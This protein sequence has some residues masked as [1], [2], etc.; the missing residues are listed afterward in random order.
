MI[1]SLLFVKYYFAVCQDIGMILES[2]KAIIA[3]RRETQ[4]L[5]QKRLAGIMGAKESM[6]SAILSGNRGLSELWIERFCAALNITL[7]ELEKP[8]PHIYDPIEIREYYDKLKK[9]HEISHVPGFRAASRAIDDWLE[10]AEAGWDVRPAAQ[11]IAIPKINEKPGISYSDSD[12]PQ[13]VQSVRVPYYDA[14]PACDPRE[15][16]PQG[17]IWMDIIHSKS[18]GS[19]YT[20]RVNGDS[21]SPDYLDGDVVLMDH[22]PQPC[23]GDIVAALIDGYESTLKIY[24]RIGDNIILTPIETKRHSPRT[25]HA[26]RV[27]IQ[28]VLVEIVRRIAKRRS[29]P[30]RKPS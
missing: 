28:G 11:E 10:A 9:L 3:D 14:V 26:S 19:W 17:Q 29:V 12:A 15:I 13:P 1:Y 8:S 27:T 2:L 6:V 21:M 4:G 5:T 23:D 7:G 24:S 22:A 25:F 30:G 20:L 18:K 16:S